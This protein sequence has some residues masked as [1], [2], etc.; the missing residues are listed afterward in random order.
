M[1]EG[2]LIPLKNSPLSVNN[3]RSIIAFI[4]FSGSIIGL[5]FHLARLKY[6]ATD[7]AFLYII[8][9]VFIGWI[10]N[11]YLGLGKKGLFAGLLVGHISLVLIFIVLFEKNLTEFVVKI[12]FVLGIPM[13]LFV[14]I[15][16]YNRL[17]RDIYVVSLLLFVFSACLIW[18]LQ[19]HLGL[20]KDK[21]YLRQKHPANYLPIKTNAHKPIFN[22]SRKGF[23]FPQIGTTGQSI[24]YLSLLYRQPHVFS[25]TMK[26]HKV[27]LDSN[28]KIIDEFKAGLYG[29]RWN[30]F[31]L[32]Q[33][34]FE[35]IHSRIPPGAIKDMFSVGK[36]MFQF[37][38]GFF[39]IT[40]NYFSSFVKKWGPER[41]F[42][43]LDE[44]IFVNT[45][46]IDNYMAPFII[47]EAEYEAIIENDP[48]GKRPDQRHKVFTYSIKK[49]DYDSVGIEVSADRK[50]IFYWA[51]GYDKNWHA[52]VNG[53][54]V[55]IYRA[56]VNF[57]A[58]VLPK[59]VSHV[60]FVYQHIRF[61]TALIVFYATFVL[62]G[63]SAVII[64][65]FGKEIQIEPEKQS[66]I[67]C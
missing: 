9:L 46:K 59:G 10:L 57:K 37:K 38:K 55:P 15:K 5:V 63:T 11:K 23:L 39:H 66:V 44:Y 62:S 16:I 64:W 61:K 7:Y 22:Q 42:R 50:G 1:G 3:L 6:P 34:Y 43:L 14:I 20:I 31:L 41:A 2:I 45:K 47:S 18:D 65:L 21:L 25:P 28:A 36:P 32:L 8:M 49:Y 54:E 40:E 52:Y 56:N 4:L 35:L 53:I 60:S 17:F 12:L 24:R 13:G 27:F 58:I 30:S 29:M 67:T 51:D 33:K 19:D 26:V 48:L